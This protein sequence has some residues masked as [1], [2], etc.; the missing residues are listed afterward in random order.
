MKQHAWKLVAIVTIFGMVGGCA[1]G[2]I[3]TILDLV[4]I[5]SAVG[6]I[7]DLFNGGSDDRAEVLLDGQVIRT[8][9]RGTSTLRLQG[10]PEGRHLLQIVSGDF[11]GIL[12]LITVDPDADVQLGQLQAE[13]GGMVRGNVTLRGGD[14]STRAAVRVPVYAIPGGTSLVA[15]GQ[16]TITLPPAGTHYVTY[17]DGNGDYVISAMAPEDYLVTATVAGYM[18]DVQLI[19]SLRV[20][21][22]QGNRNLELITDDVAVG[23]AVGVVQGRTAGGASSLGGASLRASTSYSPDIPQDTIDRIANQH[24]GD[25]RAAPWFRWRVLSTLADA[26]GSYQLPLPPGTPRINAFA[27]GYQPAFRDEAITAGS[28]AQAD[29]TLD[30]R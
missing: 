11:R 3:G 28:T 17:T 21:Q 24:G 30:E 6:Q 9:D 19:E 14:G 1:G 8:V 7:N 29:F 27:Y 15:E 12:R 26:G 18:A 25:L 5:G 16:Q 23:R 20:E 2:G 10:I 13:D 4:G 22:R